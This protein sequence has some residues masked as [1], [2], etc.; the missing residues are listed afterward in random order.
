M[1]G[2]GRISSRDLE[3]LSAYLD[4]QLSRAEVA[5]LEARLRDE[6][7]LREALDGLRQAKAALASLPSLRPPRN[8]T[9]TREMAGVRPQRRAYP[10]LRLAT[11]IATVA[12]LAV[13]GLDVLSRG[14]GRFAPGASA[15]APAAEELLQAAEPAADEG[16]ALERSAL[17]APTETSPSLEVFAEGILQATAT[18]PAEAPLGETLPYG[19]GGGAPEATLPGTPMGIGGGPP[20]GTPAP[21]AAAI[22]SPTSTPTSTPTPT[23]SPSP[24]PTPLPAPTED[25]GALAQIEQARAAEAETPTALSLFQRIELLLAGAVVV[26]AVLSLWVRRAV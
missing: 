9:L 7:L 21:A 1:T 5:R 25:A 24:S 6:A 20:E 14:A 3:R 10:A 26:F 16:E 8:F 19:V 11:A 18:P 12:F 13:S 22:P 23:T 15:P 4:G 2:L 17:L